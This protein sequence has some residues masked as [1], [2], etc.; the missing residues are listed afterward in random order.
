MQLVKESAA[1]R[2]LRIRPSE[3]NPAPMIFDRDMRALLLTAAG[4]GSGT[5]TCALIL[6]NELASSS[7]EP[8]LLIDASLSAHNLTHRFGLEQSPGF[9]DLMFSG[10]GM[11]I[12]DCI[13]KNAGHRRP[14]DV[15]PIGVYLRHG[16]RIDPGELQ[17][18]L[19]RLTERYRFVVVDGDALY[20]NQ[21]TLAIGSQADGVVLI[22]RNEHTRWEVA[23]AALQ[24]LR[25]AEARV[26]G[27]IFNARKFYLPKIIYDNL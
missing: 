10:G 26:I 21:D 11:A 4:S 8:V 15:M 22:V 7:H 16:E 5:T 9:L 27:S 14:F 12:Q 25:Q 24:R 13:V 6:A 19:A 18:L 17:E 1:R 3:S 2:S 23:Q 20:A